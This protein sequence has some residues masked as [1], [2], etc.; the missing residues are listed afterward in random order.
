MKTLEEKK[1]L[2]NMMRLFGQPVDHELIESIK[3]EEELNKAFFKEPVQQPKVML[4]IPLPF[5]H[6]LLH[7]KISNLLNNS[8]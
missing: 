8:N 2:V 6:Q 5:H 3:R 7:S 1:L 4:D